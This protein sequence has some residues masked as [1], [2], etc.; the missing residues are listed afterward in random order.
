MKYFLIFLFGTLMV[1]LWAQPANDNPCGA[2]PL[3]TN[4]SCINTP[5]TNVA[6]TDTPGLPTPG[7]ASYSGQDVFYSFVVPAS[8]S[9][10]VSLTAGTMTD[11]GMALYSAASC[12]GPF[13]LIECDDDDGTGNMSSINRSGLTPG[14]TIWVRVWNFGGGTGTFQICVTAIASSGSNTTC[15]VPNP[16]CSGSPISFVAN[17]G[18]P[19]ASALNPGNNYSCLSTSPN[20][21][22]YYL[23]IDLSG[24]LVI[25]VTAGSDVDYAIWG[26]FT[27]LANAI[28]NCNSYGVPS[29][30]SYSPSPIEQVIINGVVSGQVY[31]LLVTNYANTVQTIN[32]NE[33]VSNTAS[34]NCAIVPLPVGL[35]QW[36][37][38]LYNDDVRLSWTTASE[39]NNDYFAV[40]HSVDG[41]IWETFDIVE[42]HGNSNQSISYNSTHDTPADGTNYYRLMQVDKDGNFTFSSILSVNST[43]INS[44]TTYPNPT[45]GIVNVRKCDSDFNKVYLTDLIGTVIEVPFT[46]NQ[47][48]VTIDC[49]KIENGLYTITLISDK[50][51]NLTKQIVIN[52]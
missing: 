50:G 14:S 49:S 22:W 20:P 12:A 5:G 3:T 48:E 16:I 18:S 42:G 40:Q 37:A 29:D 25:D 2:T 24:N 31:V 32:I 30:C 17:A 7:C 26:P 51:E 39:S 52:R 46:D 47:S 45:K 13:T 8:G 28:A 1:Q 44:L 38:F 33:A 19:A 41:L 6:A 4:T 35:T 36:D 43:N 9:V 15:N 34:T 10:S 27:N 21:S 11:S 23:E